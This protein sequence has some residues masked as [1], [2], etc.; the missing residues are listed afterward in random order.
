[1]PNLDKNVTVKAKLFRG[2]GDP[3]RLRV[4]EALRDG[5]RCVSEV[6]AT[7][8]LSQPNASAHLACLR[9]CGLVEREQRGR[10][11][12]YRFSS[13]RVEAIL[14]E[15]EALLSSVAVLIE[16]CR[17]YEEGDDG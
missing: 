3:S 17:R 6:V 8:G 14:V 1:M 5:P 2:F 11:A 9:E 13:P 16:A 4:L 12:F 7:T 15:A 10:Y